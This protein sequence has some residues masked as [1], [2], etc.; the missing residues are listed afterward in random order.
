MM[1]NRA[2]RGL[3]FLIL[4]CCLANI[5]LVVRMNVSTANHYQ[6]A[7]AEIDISRIEKRLD[8]IAYNQE[9]L[10]KRQLL[11]MRVLKVDTLEPSTQP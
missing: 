2:V 7:E 6:R 5:A 11:A 9:L 3:F 10:K 4:G 8:T 1:S